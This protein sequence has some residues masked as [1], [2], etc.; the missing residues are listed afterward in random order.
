M[1][2][3][4]YIS[5]WGCYESRIVLASVNMTVSF[6]FC[7]C[8]SGDNRSSCATWLD[9]TLLKISMT[10][11]RG[12]RKNYNDNI[13]F[14]N[15]FDVLTPS[16][17]ADWRRMFIRV[18]IKPQFWGQKSFVHKVFI[19]TFWSPKC[20]WCSEVMFIRMFIVALLW[21][22]IWTKC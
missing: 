1:G 10:N 2:L 6:D 7:S 18:F 14:I 21:T 9:Q 17:L 22:L 11:I 5:N 19:S 4:S 3:E 16:W 8:K 12:W 15:A 20:F 13:I